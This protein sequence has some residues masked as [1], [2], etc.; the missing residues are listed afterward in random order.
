MVDQATEITTKDG[1]VHPQA[2][3]HRHKVQRDPQGAEGPQ[4]GGGGQPQGRE[5][6]AE[7]GSAAA[8][9]NGSN[10]PQAGSEAPQPSN[11]YAGARGAF[12]FPPIGYQS[13]DISR[14]TSRRRLVIAPPVDKGLDCAGWLIVVQRPQAPPHRLV[15][16]LASFGRCL[17]PVASCRPRATAAGTL[18]SCTSTE[19]PSLPYFL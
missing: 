1:L 2:D 17:S 16:K 15:V 3:P 9:Q 12:Q 11:G 18:L 6:A 10:E 8:S 7:A 5:G 13:A 4:K 19:T 14:G